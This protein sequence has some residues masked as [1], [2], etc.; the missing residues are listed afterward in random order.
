MILATAIRHQE[1]ALEALRQAAEAGRIAHAYLFWG[2]TGIGKTRSALALAQRLLC[3]RTPAPCGSCP[4]CERVARLTHPDLHFVLAASRA[5]EEEMRR[6]LD[7]YAQDPYHCLETPRGASIG[8]ERIRSL[9]LEAS[10]AR[11]EQGCRVILIREAERLTL[12]AAQAA[13]K[14]IEEP[15]AETF[16]VLTCTDASHLLPTILS[17]CQRVRFRALPADFLAEVLASRLEMPAERAR[18]VAG[19]AQGS[20]SRALE[21]G[22]GDAVALRD[23]ALEL[24]ERPP[25]D[26]SEAVARVQRIGRSW[27][28]E[29]ARLMVDLL[30]TWYGDLL[31]LRHGLPEEDLVHGDRVAA[32]RRQA[33]GLGLPL[34]RRRIEALEEMLEAIEQNVNPALALE[35]AL[36][37][38]HG[39]DA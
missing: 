16:L 2:P 10:K 29:R 7:A 8:I 18:V 1:A 4:P 27:D 15:Q 5:T 34:V 28:A 17:R 30:M 9:K 11:V 19:L 6:E 13:L 12:E 32:L 38:I 3:E 25:R 39:L 23:E 14:L 24:I 21:L 33:A 20:L 26:A 36:L 22:E 31:A 37:R 35:A